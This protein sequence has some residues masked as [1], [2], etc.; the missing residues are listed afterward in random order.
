[1]ACTAPRGVGEPALEIAMFDVRQTPDNDKT[2]SAR[3]LS[4]ADTD[5][6]D[7]STHAEAQAF[8][9]DHGPGDP[10]RLDGDR[11]GVACEALR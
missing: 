8:Y 3:S 7:F 2:Q 11:G 6:A 10:H 5:C 1:M 9:A 4:L